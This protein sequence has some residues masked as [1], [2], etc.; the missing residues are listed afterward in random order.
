MD[1]REFDVVVWGA[2]G[3]TGRLVAA[4]LAL[5]AP[6]SLRLGLAGRDEAKLAAVRAA[7]PERA[8]AW[9]LLLA[10]A[11]DEQSLGAL[12]ARTRVVCTTVGPYARHGLPLVSACA[13]RGTHLVDLTGEVP[14]IRDSIDRFDA[15]AR[16]AG[17]RIVHCCGF[18]SIPSDL[19][20]WLL[21]RELGP[22]ARATLVVESAKGGFSGGTI[23]SLLNVLDETAAEPTRRALVA[24]PYALSP[25]RAR[26]PDL[27]RQPDV[28]RVAFDA[29]VE[30]W[31]APF[32]MAPVNTRVVRRSNA[33][34][35]HAYGA[36]FR[37]REVM[38]FA[39]G[40]RGLLSA[41]AVMGGLGAFGALLL[42]APTRR[43]LTKRLPQPGEGPTEATRRGGHLRLTIFGEAEAGRR[44]AVRVEGA[45]DPGYQ[46]TAVML[47]EAAL[48]L[49][50]DDARLPARCGVLTPATALGLPLVERLRDAGL[51]F[52]MLSESAGTSRSTKQD[53]GD[54]PSDIHRHPR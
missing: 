6:S 23:A 54:R 43:A 37:Y 7:L 13:A 3:Y 11:A 24:D 26:E 28:G 52:E 45:G 15:L 20:V 21:H 9:P 39:R 25:D 38:G 32:L 47:G 36:R 53:G 10:E 18:D 50:L 5:R 44:A 40:G 42:F 1:A 34:L 49:A 33:L 27:G 30:R 46:L 2:T 51:S 35:G 8:R 12:A 31:T 29:F 14:F 17:A 4:H 48:C 19:G 16:G 41:T 22:M